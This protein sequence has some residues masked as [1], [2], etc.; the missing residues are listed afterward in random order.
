MEASPFGGQTLIHC[1]TTDYKVSSTQS[2]HINDYVFSAKKGNRRNEQK[3]MA[4]QTD[5]SDQKYRSLR[6][7]FD[8]LQLE[9]KAV[10]LIESGLSLFIHSVESLTHFVREEVNKMADGE[11][12]KEESK[13][14]QEKPAKK[15]A[16]KRKPRSTSTR[17]NTTRTRA[18][19][20]K[21]STKDDAASKDKTGDADSND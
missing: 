7:E 15:P 13:D 12:D 4:Q 19:K 21:T 10:F 3:N 2:V 17:K 9:E 6:K 5:K 14:K 20:S 18:T 1:E 11:K 16:A 8:D